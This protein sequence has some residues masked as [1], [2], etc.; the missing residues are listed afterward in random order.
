MDKLRNFTFVFLT[1]VLLSFAAVVQAQTDKDAEQQ[2]YFDRWTML[3]TIA[4]QAK[5]HAAF[6][7]VVEA[8]R[9]AV[10]VVDIETCDAA[11]WYALKQLLRSGKTATGQFDLTALV[12]SGTE[13]TDYAASSTGGVR[14]VLRDMP[15]GTYTLKV[16]A[17]QRPYDYLTAN[18]RYESGADDRRVYMY[19]YTETQSLKHID[20]DARFVPLTSGTWQEGAFQ[21]AIPAD[22][23]AAKAA[24]DAGL[25][26][27]VMRATL[28]TDTDMSMGIRSLATSSS[29]WL[30]RGNIRLYYGAP[31]VSIMLSGDGTL[32]VTEDTY[33]DV[34]TSLTLEDHVLYDLCLPFDM[35]REQLAEQGLRAF[36]VGSVTRIDDHLQEQLVPVDEIKAGYPYYIQATRNTTLRATDVLVRAM[37]PDSV[38]ALWGGAYMVGDYMRQGYGFSMH[39]PTELQPYDGIRTHTY[40][41]LQKMDFTVSLENEAVSRY[42]TEVTYNDDSPS[43]VSRYYTTPPM[44]R[45]QPRSVFIPVPLADKALTLTLADNADYSAASATTYPARTT[46]CEVQNLMPLREYYYKVATSDGDILTCGSFTT[47]GTVRMIHASSVSNIRDI[48]GWQNCDGNRLRYGSIFRGSEMNVGQ[49]I[50]E[51]DRQKLLDLGIRAEIDLRNYKNASGNNTYS[52]LGADIP[53]LFANLDRWSDNTLQLDVTKWSNIM[54]FLVRHVC[55]DE[56]VYFHCRVGADRTGCLAQLLQGLLGLSR[57]QM[58]HDYE[59]TSFSTAG[60]RRKEKLDPA[61]DYILQNTKGSTQQMHYF[62]FIN[63]TLGIA[64]TDLRDFIN[65]MVEG[66]SSILHLPLRFDCEDGSYFESLTDIYATCPVGSKIASGARA[67]IAADGDIEYSIGMKMEGL[68]ITFFTMALEP[69]TR[70]TLTIPAGAVID[71]DGQANPEAVTLS[72]RTP[73]TFAQQGYLYAPAISKFLS[74]GA[75]FGTRIVADN[76]GLPVNI[77]TDTDGFRVITFLDNALCLSHDGQGDRPQTARNVQW[78][79]E[80]ADD[81]F[82]LRASDGGYMTLANGYFVADAVSQTDATAFVLLSAD[83][84][85]QLVR[86][87]QNECMLTAARN[88]NIEAADIEQLQATLCDLET[89]DYTASIQNATSGSTDTWTLSEPAD[90]KAAS[91]HAYNVGDFGGEL[92]N[93]HGYVS[94]TV[95]VDQPGLYRLSATIFVRQGSN[96]NCYTLGKQG[97]MLS[98]A[99]LSINDRYWTI[100][101]DWYSDATS[102]ST[103]DTQSQARNLMNSGKYKVEL[104]AYVDDTKRLNIRINQPAYTTFA[105]CVFNN[106][107]LTRIETDGESGADPDDDNFGTGINAISLNYQATSQQ[108][109]N[110]ALQQQAAAPHIQDLQGRQLSPDVTRLR[111]GIYIIDGKKVFVK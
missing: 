58:Y 3:T 101:P 83:E 76:I 35:S 75:N 34:N 50:T 105:W 87:A 24:F 111:T 68:M 77:G 60:E 93:K 13:V 15:A 96:A 72:F 46:L 102:T 55:A 82:Y 109:T 103:P 19:F 33:A 88:A 57:D 31:R 47:E 45:D 5:D 39:L 53:Y 41:N 79:I 7:A 42:L 98:N 99:S 81:G 52:A 21:R 10:S 94:Q 95:S 44:R 30:H 28:D 65:A 1:A 66:E 67:R 6:D 37:R 90:D 27:N 48:G 64:V 73:D 14:Y 92:L 8:A 89:E 97:Y 63:Q 32:P 38:P 80:P 85:Q 104:Y 86:Q 51:A 17:F 84:Q 59:L 40:S 69:G 62:N 25:Y 36:T 11:V 108:S 100:I 26:W 61:V 107:T 71:P 106:F 43:V 74:R 2:A 18:A 23:T 20:D 54:K 9:D 12:A 16:Q 22:L 4:H 70:Y 56:P 29:Y 49:E 110:D 91:S 78:T